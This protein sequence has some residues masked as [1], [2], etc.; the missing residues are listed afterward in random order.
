LIG[1]NQSHSND[2][3]DAFQSAPAPASHNNF[4]AFSTPA[5]Q[6]SHNS[7]D[8]FSTPVAQPSHNSFDAFSTPAAPPA[9]PRNQFDAFSAPQ[10]APQNFQSPQNFGN[11]Q[12]SP[13]QFNAFSG[14]PQQ[15]F[16]QQSHSFAPHQ[17]TAH[18]DFGD[19]EGASAPAPA[20][21][22]APKPVDK[23]ASL[24]GLVNLTDL[25]ASSQKD[26]APSNQSSSTNHSS[27]AGLDGFSQSRNSMVT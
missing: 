17:Q 16:T 15:N 13:Q 3:F 7:F 4:D 6:P 25:N 20:P 5:A 11:F 1:N 24:G 23:W 19:F 22:S 10:S 12:S 8:A 2:G 21:A 27:F 9:P 14:A 26:S 18:D